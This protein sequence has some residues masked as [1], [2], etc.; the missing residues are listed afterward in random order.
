MRT[1]A[2]AVVGLW[3]VVGKGGGSIGPGKN[4]RRLGEPIPFWP[5]VFMAWLAP[6]RPAAVTLILGEWGD[7]SLASFPVD[8]VH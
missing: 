2:G 3:D 8:D 4:G 7:S 1:I 5:P 6:H